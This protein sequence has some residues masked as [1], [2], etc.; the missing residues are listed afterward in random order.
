MRQQV[1]IVFI[2][3]KIIMDYTVWR[4]NSGT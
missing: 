3:F 2:I 1:K 4:R